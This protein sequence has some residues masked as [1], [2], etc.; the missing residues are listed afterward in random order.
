M[1]AVG[2]LQVREAGAADAAEVIALWHAT[3]LI[4][5]WNDPQLDFDQATQGPT[6]AVLLG[7]GTTGELLATAMVGMDGH[8]GWIYY[9]AVHPTARAQGHGAQLLTDCEQWLA[10][11]GARKI[12]LMVREGNDV[13]SFYA[14][15]GY[16]DQQTTVLGRW[17]Q[18]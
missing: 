18:G 2:S 13:G 15:R 16:T 8:R 3:G 11:H 9:F 5:P 1:T 10:E 7:C 12:Q 4:R 6:S 17:L 14:S